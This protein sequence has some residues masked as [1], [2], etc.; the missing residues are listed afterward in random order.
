VQSLTDIRALNPKEFYWG[1]KYVAFT[2]HARLELENCGMDVL[3][4]ID[5]LYDSFPCKIKRR[6][7]RNEKE[8]CANWNH[9]CYRIILFEDFCINVQEICWVVKHVKPA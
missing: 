8:V 9:V 5:M 1:D 6:H 4:L 2:D 7:K 3:N